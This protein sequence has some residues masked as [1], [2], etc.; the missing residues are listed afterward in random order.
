MLRRLL[1][2]SGI[3][4]AIMGMVLALAAGAGPLA[5]AAPPA[6]P[7]PFE[8]PDPILGALDLDAVTAIDLASFPLVPEIGENA[9]ALYAHSL[10]RGGD[11]HAFIKVGDCMTDTPYFLI[12]IGEDDYA[13]GEYA[14]LEP[15]IAQFRTA[16]RDSF[17]RQ[18]QAAA[19]GFNA[20]S[21]LDAMWANPQFCQAGETPLSCELRVME[22][23]IALIMFGTN[24]VQ[25]LTAEQF[26]YFLRALVVETVRA[27]VLPVLSTFPHRPEFPEQTTLFNQIVA[28]VALEYDVPLINL[29]LALEPLP[30][31]GVDLADPTH[32]TVPASGGVCA[33][34]DENLAAGFTVRN[35]LTLQ[36]LEAVLAAAESVEGG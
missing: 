16:E 14:H 33:F 5:G 4:G 12:P 36:T 6:T 32:M 20:A 11:P 15:V 28:G 1:A 19:G 27:G 21:I 35:L 26:A 25:Y 34:V 22:P 9:R 3:A 18:S 31:R 24:D 17:A 13:L 7:T 30:D 2:L 29:W 8:L 23:S 10:A